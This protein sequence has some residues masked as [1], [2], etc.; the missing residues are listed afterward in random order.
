MKTHK[1]DFH[2]ISDLEAIARTLNFIGFDCGNDLLAV[3]YLIV[4]QHSA[5]LFIDPVKVDTIDWQGDVEVKP[6]E[7]FEDF[8]KTNSENKTVVL[9]KADTSVF[10][11]NAIAESAMIL[12][13]KSP[14]VEIRQLKLLTKS[15]KSSTLM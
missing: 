12:L 11:R 14:T 1:A 7:A 13:T 10:V 9:D 2:V 8:L 4:D 5:N 6:Y 3:S 15:I